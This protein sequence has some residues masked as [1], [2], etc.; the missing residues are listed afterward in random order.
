MKQAKVTGTGTLIMTCPW[1]CQRRRG[2]G[3]AGDGGGGGG[4]GAIVEGRTRLGPLGVLLKG[5]Y[6]N[7]T[8]VFL[9][10]LEATV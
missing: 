7:F 5:R 8:T 6:M 1:M 10:V 9:F 2:G 4:G 3:E